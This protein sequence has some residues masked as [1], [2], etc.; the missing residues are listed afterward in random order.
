MWGG[1]RRES[2][3]GGPAGRGPLDRWAVRLC[4]PTKRCVLLA[5]GVHRDTTARESENLQLKEL[6]DICLS[7]D[8]LHNM[9]L[10]HIFNGH[11]P[12]NRGCYKCQ[13]CE[14]GFVHLET[15]I[16]NRRQTQQWVSKRQMSQ[17]GTACATMRRGRMVVINRSAMAEMMIAFQVLDRRL[18]A[19]SATF[20]AW[21]GT[22]SHKD[23]F[24][25]STPTPC[26]D[27]DCSRSV[28]GL[29]VAS[30]WEAVCCTGR[31][32]KEIHPKTCGNRPECQ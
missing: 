31:Q 22:F 27:G 4:Q 19:C 6:R 17:E 14:S 30:S 9:S 1:R 12:R 16:L 24:K 5:R 13:E 21:C 28:I 26:E 7:L 25:H 10:L 20:V 8:D 3:L 29:G 18:L 32:F 2:S 11:C 23:P 15:D